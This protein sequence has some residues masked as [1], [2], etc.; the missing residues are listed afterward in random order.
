MHNPFTG[1]FGITDADGIYGMVTKVSSVLANGDV[2]VEIIVNQIDD[3]ALFRP[4]SP[5]ALVD[6]ASGTNGYTAGSKTLYLTDHYTQQSAVGDGVDFVVGDVVTIE[7]RETDGLG[8]AIYSADDVIA[9]AAADG[10][11]CTLTTGISA[12]PSTIETIMRLRLYSSQTTARKTTAATAVSFAG[13]TR[14]GLILA[15]A[16]NHRWQ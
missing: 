7:G 12:L 14:D 1:L 16:R 13:D 5:T 6:R 3:P 9:T 8:V 10:F 4:W 2:Q 11:S 15:T